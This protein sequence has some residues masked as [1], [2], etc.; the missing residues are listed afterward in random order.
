MQSPYKL[1]FPLGQAYVLKLL[2]AWIGIIIY[3]TIEL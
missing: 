1:H 3:L 2:D